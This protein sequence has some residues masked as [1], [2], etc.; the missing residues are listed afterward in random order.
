MVLGTRCC[1]YLTCTLTCQLRDLQATL[2]RRLGVNHIAT[3]EFSGE[4]WPLVLNKF[5][6]A[7][8]VH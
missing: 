1:A 8:V 7:T 4:L 2:R 3:E 6:P 5:A